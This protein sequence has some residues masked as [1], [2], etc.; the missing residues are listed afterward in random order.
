MATDDRIGSIEKT[1]AAIKSGMKDAE[2]KIEDVEI[3]VE[4]VAAA[5]NATVKAVDHKH[6]RFKNALRSIK[7]TAVITNAKCD[8]LAEAMAKLH[9]DT[10][11]SS[12]KSAEEKKGKAQKYYAHVTVQH[13]ESNVLSVGKHHE[14]L[15]KDKGPASTS[16]E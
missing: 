13:S 8:A 3:L 15:V 4:Q 9:R 6:N 11:K 5:C 1:S 14:F 7:E 16:G 12:S 10:L 2:H